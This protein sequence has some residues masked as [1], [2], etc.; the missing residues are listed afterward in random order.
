MPAAG[1]RLHRHRAA[2]GRGLRGVQ[3]QVV[4]HALHQLGVEGKRRNLGRIVPVDRDPRRLA[5]HQR[6]GAVEHLAEVGALRPNLQ[7]TRE[8]EEAGDQRIGAVHLVE[9]KPATSRATSFSALRL[10]LSISADALIVP[11]RIA[12]L[13]RQ[14]RRELPERGQ[15]VGPAHRLFRL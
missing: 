8:L 11:E 12:Q 1:A 2:G 5:F 7:R 4:E 3:H 10:L 6:D 15:P 9:M 13:V 14:P